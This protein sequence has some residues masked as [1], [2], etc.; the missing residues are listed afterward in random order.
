M[1][2]N[3]AL[4]SLDAISGVWTKEVLETMDLNSTFKTLF[5]RDNFNVYVSAICSHNITDSSFK[6]ILSYLNMHNIRS[7]SNVAK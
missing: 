1:L 7:W 4:L 6:I 2:S 5:R 3:I